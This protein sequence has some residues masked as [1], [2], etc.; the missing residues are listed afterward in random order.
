MKRQKKSYSPRRLLFLDYLYITIG[1]LL[2]AFAISWVFVPNKTVTGGV[3]GISILLYYLFGW[4][5]SITSFLINIPLFWV[6]FRFL[7]G[8]EF[9]FKT[10]YGIISLTFFLSLTEPLKQHPL[11]TNT[12]LASIYGGL[13]LGAGLGIVF[14]GRA[15]TGGTDLAAR[16]IQ[17]YTGISA[18]TLL[19]VI[20]GSIIAAAGVI[21]G[22][23]RVLFA[24]ISLFITSKT[25]D[26]VQQGV[27]V[28]KISYIITDDEE[29]VSKAILFNLNRG[30]T[31]LPSYGGFTGVERNM[32]MTVVS[33]S[34]VSRLKEIVRQI[35]PRAF[36]IVSDVQEV[37][38][39]GF[40]YAHETSALTDGR[41][42]ERSP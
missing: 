26:L 35:D 25:I 2:V 39:E 22:I 6:G 29:A 4:K 17:N 13:L 20:D 31:K 38:G 30:C 24:L 3:T 7:G 12:L 10:L 27:T 42:D 28:G 36:V 5:V 19:L 15:T 34:E 9:A 1:S 23:E 40:T 32:L 41:T 18:G 11:T 21:F 14:R 8:R 16:L 37:L 33:R